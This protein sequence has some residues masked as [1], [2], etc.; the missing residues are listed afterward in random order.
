MIGIIRDRIGFQGLLMSDD[1]NMQALKGS[2][3]DRTRRMIAAGVDVALHCNGDPAEMIEVARAA[4]E[5]TPAAA[6]RAEAAV[7]AR[8][9]AG[10]ALET[11]LAGLA[12]G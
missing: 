8:P 1:L 2:V 3:G 9:V 6:A 5:M 4:G 11:A 7:A 10:L 12:D